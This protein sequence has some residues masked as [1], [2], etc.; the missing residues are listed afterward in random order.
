MGKEPIPTNGRR[1]ITAAAW[2]AVFVGLL[3]MAITFGV[4]RGRVCEKLMSHREK[5]NKCEATTEAIRD[6]LDTIN[7]AVI[8][9]EEKL[10]S[11]G[12]R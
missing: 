12:G 3:G 1:W 7:E 5:I 11:I 4:E 9:I 8:R 2:G 6:K 10:I